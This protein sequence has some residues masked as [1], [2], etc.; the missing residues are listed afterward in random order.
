MRLWLFVG[1]YY[2]KYCAIILCALE[3]FFIGIDSLQYAEK[4]PTAANLLLLFFVYD[5]LYALNY[6]LP[7]SLLLALVLF[8]TAFIHSNQYTALL[9]IGY[10]I[11][12]ILQPMLAINALFIAIFVGLSATPFVYMQEKAEAIIYKDNAGNI[13][14]NLLVKYNN[15][16]VYFGKINPLLQSATNIKIFTLRN[17]QLV[18][19]AQ[20][21][22]AFFEGK[23]WVLHGVSFLTLPTPFLLGSKALKVQKLPVL[24]TLKGFRP[25]VLDTIY[26]NKPAVSIT[27]AL[28]SLH[29]LY[30]QKADTK[31]IRGFLYV[32]ILLPFFV[33]LTAVLIAYHTP[34]L[35][36]YENLALL[37]LK[38]ILL[39][40]VLWGLFFAMGKFSISGVFL[41]EVGV[42]GPFLTL[43]VIA[44][45]YYKRLNTKL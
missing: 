1:S 9:S 30:R 10:S 6:T 14:E 28:R 41:P 17:K 11:K 45:S 4:F 32:S 25:K 3:F 2:L 13:S 31:K 34:K 33:P 44:F 37:S 36:R 38:F 5:G 26:Q 16:Y 35:A 42:L 12:Q 39:S 19:F 29:V 21:P 15:D 24:K 8:Y 27:D 43:A 23:F 40:L 20:A 18:T 22:S 7:L